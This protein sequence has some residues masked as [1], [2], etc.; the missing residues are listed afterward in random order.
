MYSNTWHSLEA[1]EVMQRLETSV[2]GLTTAVAQQR[3]AEYG[4]NTLPEKKRRSLFKILLGQFSDFM[5]LVLLAAALISGLIG[6]PQDAIAILVIVLLN[7][8]IGAIQEYRAERAV[9]ALQA[10]SAPEAHVVRDD[11]NV[12]LAATELVPGDVVILQAGDIVPADLRLLQVDAMLAD[13]SA[14]TGE[15]T[16]ANKQSDVISEADLSAG[17]QLN[18][19]FKSLSLIHI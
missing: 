10:M 7:A 17:D 15:S 3:Q 13:E 4:P 8:I 16:P 2:Q 12:T 19:A 14:L 9:A 6:D 11:Q 1:D 5:I 18:I